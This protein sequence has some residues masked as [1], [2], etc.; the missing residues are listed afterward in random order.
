MKC[1]RSKF[2]MCDRLVLTPVEFVTAVKTAIIIFGILFL[3]NLFAIRPFGGTGVLTFAVA[4]ITGTVLTPV[5][6]PFIPGRAFAFKGWL[7]GIIVTAC[8]VSLNGWFAVNSLLLAIGY[9]LALPSYSAFL[10][11][12]F[13]GS[14]TYTSF[15]GVI[16]EMKTALPA[17][18]I[19]MIVGSVLLFN[20]SLFRLGG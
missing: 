11:M 16:K 7:L 8:M 3:I 4:L 9:L 15:S 1:G 5:L 18:I 12:N 20:K 13:T 2:T 10:A 14:P 6:L 17:I 19:S